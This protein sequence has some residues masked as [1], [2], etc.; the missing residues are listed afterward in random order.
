MQISQAWKR[1]LIGLSTS[2]F[3]W[4]A[5]ATVGFYRLIPTLPVYRDLAERYFCSHPIEYATATLFFVGIATLILKAVAMRRERWAMRS[6]AQIAT[7]ASGANSA[8]ARAARLQEQIDSR[9]TRDRNSRL[10]R[11]IRD[12]CDCI[13][14]RHSVPGLEQHLN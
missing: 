4:G 6:L 12:V 5:G 7:A 13:R 10:A 11:R 1:W 14:G 3:L 9:P 8:T 2:P